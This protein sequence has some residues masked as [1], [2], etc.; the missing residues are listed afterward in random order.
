MYYE[1]A[2]YKI[3]VI[4]ITIVIII[5][6]IMAKRQKF[7]LQFLDPSNKSIRTLV[8]ETWFAS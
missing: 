8:P 6:N 5:I 7:V 4:F 2:A 3:V 1:S